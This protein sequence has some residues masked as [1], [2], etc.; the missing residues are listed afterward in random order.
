[1]SHVST[2]TSTAKIIPNSSLYQRDRCAFSR[3]EALFLGT[4]VIRQSYG[5]TTGENVWSWAARCAKSMRDRLQARY[6]KT[7]SIRFAAQK[8]KH[9]VVEPSTEIK[10]IFTCFT[11]G[12]CDTGAMLEESRSA[13]LG[14]RI[15]PSTAVSSQAHSGPG[16][17]SDRNSRPCCA[18]FSDFGFLT[19]GVSSPK[20]GSCSVTGNWTGGLQYTCCW[21]WWG[22]SA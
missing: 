19:R 15:A 20:L 3:L 9:R 7:V 5:P 14:V 4:L 1:M 6:G 18:L 2:T 21:R 12:A 16:F 8:R 13:E 22:L 10:E 11:L 17:H